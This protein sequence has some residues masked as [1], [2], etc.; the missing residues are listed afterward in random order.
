MGN[1]LVR[2]DEQ[3][4]TPLVAQLED[5]LFDRQLLRS[6]G[7]R[8]SSG[9]LPLPATSKDAALDARHRACEHLLERLTER[10]SHDGMY[11]HL[12]RGALAGG[13]SAL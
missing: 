8:T 6:V 5:A 7:A 4:E 9:A 11:P 12:C 13:A 1:A 10:S 3:H 2:N